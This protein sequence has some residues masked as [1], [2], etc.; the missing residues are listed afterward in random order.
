MTD[1]TTSLS[2]ELSLRD[3]I[4]LFRRRRAIFLQTFVM[5][6]VIGLVVTFMTKPVYRSASRI[7]VE[8]KQIAFGQYNANDP[9]SN[10]FLSPNGHDVLTQIEVLQSAKLMNEVFQSAG[11][12]NRSVA[13]GISQVG[14]TDVVEIT[15]ESENPISAEKV[16]AAV[17]EQYLKFMS[18][19]RSSEIVNALQF[20]KSRYGEAQTALHKAEDEL[21]RYRQSHQIANLDKEREERIRTTV[22]AIDETRRGETT[23]SAAQA[24]LTQLETERRRLPL[25]LET[26][27]TNTNPQ[28]EIV[29][30]R[31]AG[32]KN[33][34]AAMLVNFKPTHVKLQELDAQIADIETR[35]TN[36][37]P[38]LTTV[39]KTPNPAVREFDDKIAEKRAVVAAGVAELAGL[40][41]RAAAAGNGLNNYSPMEIKIARLQRSIDQHREA[42][43]LLGRSVEDLSIREKATHDPIMTIT[44]AAKA[45]Q[46]AP[47][48][49]NNLLYSILA[50]LVL[51]LGFALLQEYLD[52]RIN[53]PEDARRIMDAPVLGYVPLVETEENRILTAARQ[54]GSLLESYRVMRTN[55]QFAAVDHPTAALLVTSTVPGEGKSVTASNLAV[56]MALDGKSVI[57][58]D[59]DL[60]RPTIHAKYGAE[61]RPGLTNVL[62]GHTTLEEAL[63]TTEV[64]GLRILT[65]G[66]L[67]PNPAE[68]LNSR[69]MRDLHAKLRAAADIVIFDS[70]PMLASADAQV[71]S[72]DVDGVMY[73]VQFGEARKSALRHASELFGQSRARILGVVF[74][75][76][77][78]AARRDDYYYG[79]YRY[80]NYYTSPQ[81]GSDGE[82]RRSEFEQLV[83]P[84]DDAPA[85]AVVS[86]AKSVERVES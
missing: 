31:L 10:L 83:A 73:V 74:N 61:Q 36:L 43:I 77:D 37:P 55:V 45:V 67:P 30:E 16:A 63:K 47:R 53:S 17:P 56:A 39:S 21:S 72:A 52:D 58:V 32:L 25:S 51:G 22:A 4:D 50:G 64:P 57:L 28:I 70:P 7:L 5:V 15:C 18:K 59:A 20:A 44:P 82:R 26:P 13:V 23:L 80:Y 81:I 29:K 69:A 76:I 62:V 9:L 19:S 49:V 75:K 3:Y 65:S 42:A 40:K 33:Q 14:E 86:G 68:L 11:V 85:T 48:K 78:L 66:P 6:V 24:Q 46:V 1:E 2:N 8:G 35:L 41:A 84:D 38:T 71:L 34:R 12:A 60:R 27:T 79:Y 54:G